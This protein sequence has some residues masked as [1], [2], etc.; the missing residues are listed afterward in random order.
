MP[1]GHAITLLLY[2]R[3]RHFRLTARRY[4]LVNASITVL[5]CRHLR[6]NDDVPS[7]IPEFSDSSTAAECHRGR[8]PSMIWWSSTSDE[9]FE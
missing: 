8:V 6:F 4:A 1:R 7:S 2:R 9:L 3:Y 5:T